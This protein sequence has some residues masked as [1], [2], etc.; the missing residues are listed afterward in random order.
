M[1]DQVHLFLSPRNRGGPFILPGTEF[2]FRRF[3]RLAA[4]L[5]SSLYSLGAD[6][7]ENTASKNCSI[8][9]VNGYLA[10]ARILFTCLFVSAGKYL[11]SS[12]L[13][14]A[15]VHR[16]TARQRVYTPQYYSVESSV[17]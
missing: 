13:A 10:I 14:T 3:L 8:F 1:E 6:P 16:V 9:I 7:T 17:H 12:H 15:A 11:P 4:G 2:P 5:G